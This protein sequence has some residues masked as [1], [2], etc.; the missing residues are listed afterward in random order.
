MIKKTPDKLCF[1]ARLSS[2]PAFKTV[3][4]H[5]RAQPPLHAAVGLSAASP[6]PPYGRRPG[7]TL[8]S[9]AQGKRQSLPLP[10]RKNP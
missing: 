7:F 3:K 9:L 10:D 6:P 1:C 4:E 5:I 2:A 8:Q